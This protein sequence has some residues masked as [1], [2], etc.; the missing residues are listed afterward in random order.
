MEHL[1][2]DAVDLAAKP[3]GLR[4][5]AAAQ[6][7][8]AVLQPGL[9]TDVDPVVDG[10]RQHRR[11]RQ[12]R[13]VGDEHLDVTGRDVGVLVALRPSGHLADHPQAVLGPQVV[14]PLGHLTFAE[15]HLC[16]TAGVPQVDEDHPAVV[17]PPSHPAGEGDGLANVLG[18]QGAG[19]VGAKHFA[20]SSRKRWS[21]LFGRSLPRPHR[22]TNLPGSDATRFPV[23]TTRLLTDREHVLARGTTIT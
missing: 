16:H 9:L 20:G 11:L 18:T 6:V 10:E 23:P 4:R 12:H 7:E 14:R 19:V 21:G 1:A 17:A 15:N 5:S 2:R 3:H 22:L 8:V 13:Q